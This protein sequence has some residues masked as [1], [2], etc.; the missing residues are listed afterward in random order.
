MNKKNELTQLLIRYVE[1]QN[2]LEND[3]VDIDALN[4]KLKQIADIRSVA[5]SNAIKSNVAMHV[6]LNPAHLEIFMKIRS[7]DSLMGLPPF[8]LLR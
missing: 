1:L 4:I 5:Q 8:S 7:M 3:A 2:I 6:K